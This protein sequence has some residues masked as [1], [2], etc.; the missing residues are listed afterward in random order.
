MGFA[1]RHDL[2]GRYAAIYFAVLVSVMFF[3]VLEWIERWYLPSRS[4]AAA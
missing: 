3:A 1:E 4:G 2:P